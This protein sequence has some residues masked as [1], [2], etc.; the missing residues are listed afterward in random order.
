MDNTNDNFPEDKEVLPGIR[1]NV[2]VLGLV[3]LFNDISSEML[4][5]LIPIF[6]TAVLGAPVAVVGLIE[7]IA[8]ATA[9]LTKAYSGWISD[10]FRK[11]RP[12]IALGYGLSAVSKPLLS[13]ATGWP[14]VLGLRF[15]DRV[16]KGVRTAARDALIAD[17]TDAA[18]WGRAFGFH[19][20]LDTSGAVFGPLLALALLGLLGDNLRLVFLLAFIPAAIGVL[21]IAKVRE[22]PRSAPTSQPNFS[23]RWSLFDRRFKVFLLVVLVF[24]LGNSSDAFLILRAKSL[25]GDST[26]LTVLA[27]ALYNVVYALAS[28]P[29]GILSDR[30]GRKWVMGGGFVVFAAV[31]F[32]FALAGH[33]ETIWVLFAV[34]GFYI[35]MTEGV[36]KAFTVDLV[37]AELRGTALGSYHTAVGVMSL[38]ASLLAG[39]LWTYVSPE[40]TFALGGVTAIL[41]AAML[42]LVHL[43]AKKV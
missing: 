20:A 24:S 3:S 28:T 35:A 37:P 34:Y 30:I 31:Y 22:R 36:G 11:R 2:L 38:P 4:Y 8:E 10:K 6:L 43:S 7:G 42:P 25:L 17:S 18:H 16:G 14:V 1:R 27:Y 29:A 13:L 21:L 26:F 41:A 19:R 9:S 39:L 40:A 33:P 5:P 12:L 23:I 15:G 32:G